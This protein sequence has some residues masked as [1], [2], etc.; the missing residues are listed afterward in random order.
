MAN[1]RSLLQERTEQLDLDF[2]HK[3]YPWLAERGRNCIVSP[4]SDG[5][6]CG[7]FMSHFLD[8]RIRGFYDGKILLLEHGFRALDCVFLDMEIFRKPVKSIGQHMLLYNVNAIPQ[9]W[10][11]FENCLSPNN[12]RGYDVRHTFRL[13]YP[14]GTIHLLLAILGR[15]LQVKIARDAIPP[16]LFTDGTW[17][18]LFRYMENALNWLTFL[19]ADE[20]DTPLHQLFLNDHYSMHQVLVIMNEFLRKRDAIS[21]S[22]ERGDRIAIT[23]RG[24]DGKP[25]NVEQV[26]STYSAKTAAKERGE[27]FILL[28]SEL[29]EW[30][31]RPKDWAWANWDVYEFTK[32]EIAASLSGAKFNELLTKNPLSFAVT[33]GNRIEY[34]LEEPS[35]LL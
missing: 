26:G 33:A 30:P 2:I 32:S 10:S 19:R 12:L 22:R 14:F 9:I 18:T 3:N 7:L 15:E 25:H 20:Q 11:E 4:D 6:L 16:L 13:K 17:M 8:W 35:K 34:T 23:L 31:Y 1:I 29:T 27:A 21:V 28:L 24:G 5:L